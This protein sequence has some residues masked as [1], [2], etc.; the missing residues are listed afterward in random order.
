[1]K[2]QSG[3]TLVELMLA[4]AVGLI[5]VAIIAQIYIGSKQ[6]YRT[7]DDLARLQEDG[8]YAIESVSRSL[9]LAGYW[10]DF[11][12]TYLTLFPPSTEAIGGTEG[13]G[14]T[15]PDTLIVR[16]YGSG[17]AGAADNSI[18]DCIGAGVDSITRARLTFSVAG[19]AL[20]CARDGGASIRLINN[21]TNLQ[22]LYGVDT[23][24]DNVADIYQTASPAPAW[25]N[26][27]VVRLCIEMQT[28]ND[29]VTPSA[30]TYID[31]SGF[32]VMAADRR[33]HRTF[34]ATVALRNRLP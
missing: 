14:S 24:V 29:N 23:G 27:R 32:P 6:T 2:K 8:R 13:G 22:I 26:V 10:P 34:F 12:Q 33:F 17:P 9:R 18:R 1:M 20:Q 4:I 11:S 30:Q 31:C 25:D 5:L 16:H 21:V 7:Q 3:F 28:A 15:V 19:N